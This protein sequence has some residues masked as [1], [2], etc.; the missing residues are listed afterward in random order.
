MIL[1]ETLIYQNFVSLRLVTLAMADGRT[2]ERHVED[3]GDA[4]TVLPFDPVR[5]VALFVSQPRAAVMRAG[6]GDILEA[7][8]G[9]L[10]ADMA[11]DANAAEE[12]LEEAGVRLTALD[13]VARS[14]SMPGVSTERNWLYHAEYGLAD[15]VGEGGGVADEN[16]Q[17]TVH[18]I[19]LDR[20]ACMADAGEI[21]DMKTLL[22]IQTLRLRRPELFA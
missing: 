9:S 7:P 18:E 17:I 3:H 20:V 5:R 4:S 15:R 16:E 21:P 10:E 13:L 22:L 1:G 12:A 11:P 14:W 2:A 6:E 8:A 19:P